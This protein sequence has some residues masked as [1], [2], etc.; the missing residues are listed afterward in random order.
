MFFPSKFVI[1]NY[2]TKF[3]F[4]CLYYS[5]IIDFKLNCWRRRS[6][7]S[8]NHIMCL[9]HIQRQFIDFKP[10]SQMAEFLIYQILK[11]IDIWVTQKNFGIIGKHN[12]H[13]V[14]TTHRKVIDVDKE[15]KRP[16]DWSLGH[17]ASYNL[18]RRF[19]AIVC[20]ILVSI[21]Q[22]TFAPGKCNSTY[23]IMI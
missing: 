23:T 22:I 12:C 19:Y 10:C 3:G 17:S 7:I 5:F 4:T 8:K 14:L 13:S 21:W 11:I 18:L 2:T 6:L 20:N 15:K 16:N 9:L 1:Y